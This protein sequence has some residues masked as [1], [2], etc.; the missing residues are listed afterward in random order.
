MGNLKRRPRGGPRYSLEDNIKM[1]FNFN[2]FNVHFIHRGYDPSDM[3]IVNTNN[4]V[5]NI[6]HDVKCNT[7][8]S[9]YI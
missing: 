5:T 8:I 7:F 3:E 9:G 6:I 4:K 2:L 1:V